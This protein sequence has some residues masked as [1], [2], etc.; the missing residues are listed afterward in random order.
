MLK[1][2]DIC[3]QWFI[4]Y[5]LILEEMEETGE[6]SITALAFIRGRSLSNVM[7]IIDEAQNTSPIQMKMVL[8]RLGEGS[9]MVVTG[10]LTQVDLPKGQKSGLTEAVKILNG[11]K[12]IEILKLDAVD[13]VRHSV[14]S[15]IIK[16]YEK[17]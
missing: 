16:A 5:M 14:V 17:L 2:A 3:G 4:Y 6:L 1:K 12:G 7:F 13:I 8:T 10:D 11:I 15:K 9:K